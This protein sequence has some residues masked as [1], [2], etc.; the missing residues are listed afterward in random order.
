MRPY[1]VSLFKEESPLYLPSEPVF[2]HNN[3]R[4]L[5][6]SLLDFRN[7]KNNEYLKETARLNL[8]ADGLGSTDR[9]SASMENLRV[10]M[11]EL[12][13]VESVI[14]FPDEITASF[15]LVSLFE[16]KTFFLVDYETS[17]SFYTVLRL[18]NNIEF[19]H[20]ENL[21]QLAK[22]LT[23]H[24]EKVIIID[25]LY[26]WLGYTGPVAEIVKLAKESQAVIVANEINSFGLL[27][28]DGRGFVDLFYL[29]DDVTLEIGSF[30]R[31]LGGFGAYI[32][33][34]RYL[35]NKI[36][37]NTNGVYKTLPKFMIEVNLAGM[38]FLKD[39]KGNKNA[40]QKLW[41]HS[42]YFI[43]RLKQIGLRTK[44]ETPIIVILFNNNEEAREFSKQLFN[45][46]IIAQVQKERVRF[47]ISLE[48]T[49]ADLDYTL[50][51][52]EGITKNLGIVPTL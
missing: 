11:S 26:E 32:G 39:E 28:R 34:K 49:K 38:S 25:G 20:H 5:N 44:S 2:I 13:K 29:Y 3:K 51:R 40:F 6:F 8:F 42:R 36:I 15:A 31:F 21:E 17:P 33:A 7:L 16:P 4:Y 43:N 48:H 37:E 12:K 46:G 52:I 10:A 41:S 1:Q 50:D 23:I 27:G 14:L 45:E 24:N 9:D 47:I 18:Y 30:D 35:I 22:L 19:Y